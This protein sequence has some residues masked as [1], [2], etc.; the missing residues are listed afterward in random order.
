MSILYSIT[1]YY[2]LL[3]IDYMYIEAVHWRRYLMT[4]CQ[5]DL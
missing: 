3:H 5:C 1:V 2:P 4:L